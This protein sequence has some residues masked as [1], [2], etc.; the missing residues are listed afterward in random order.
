[1]DVVDA[2]T[3]AA[4]VLRVE[5]S[6]DVSPRTNGKDKWV[7]NVSVDQREREKVAAHLRLDGLVV[8]RVALDNKVQDG[9][10]MLVL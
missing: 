10:L 3:A 8:F 2:S 7:L 1:M 9:L 5:G 6:N 4:D